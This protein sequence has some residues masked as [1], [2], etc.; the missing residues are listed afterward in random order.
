MKLSLN[1]LNKYL[2]HGLNANDLAYRLTMAGLEVESIENAGDDVIFELEI[3]PNRP[4][5]L[6]VLGL[7]REVSA[8]TDKDMIAPIVHDYEDVA[9]VDIVIED[10]AGCGRYIGTIIEG[11]QVRPLS[12][13]Y[14]S[15]L[16]ALGLKL[17]SNIVDITNFVMFEF[18]Q[19]LHAF[20]LD[21]LEGSKI[22][23][24]RAKKGEKIITLDEVERELDESILVIADARKPVAIAGIMGGRD[25]GVTATTKK[26]LLEAAFFD[27]GVVRRGARRLGL[28]SD[29]CYRFERGVTWKNVEAGSNRATDLIMQMAGGSIS[30]RRDV[31]ASKP[32][33]RRA[34]IIVTSA[35]IQALLGASLEPVRVERILK[36]LG[37]IVATAANGWVVI[38]PHFRNDLRSK[39]DIIEELARVV[40]YDNLPMSLPHVKADNIV[41]DCDKLFFN[42]RVRDVMLAQ[43]FNEVVTY[44]LM[45]RGALDKICYAEPVIR[46]QN[47]M[48]AEHEIMRPT[49]LANLLQ[50]VAYNMNRG[51]KDLRLVEVGKCYVPGRES[52]VLSIVLT[53]RREADWRRPG[54]DNVDFYDLK[55][56][57]EE[58]FTGLRV[59]GCVFNPAE[60]AVLEPGQGATI[61]LNGKTIGYIGKV[62]G[63]VVG[64]FEIKKLNV[65]FAEI[66]LDL[67]SAGVSAR[68]K[69]MPLNDFPAAVRDI[70]LAVKDVSFDSMRGVCQE[71]G[72]GLLKQIEFIELYTGDK[73]EDGYKGYVLSLTYQAPDRTLTDEEVN[74]LHEELVGRLVGR[75]GVKRR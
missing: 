65:F 45:S 67:L 33:R 71:H 7:A 40:G 1:W 31:T 52:L 14:S 48:S 43:G 27:L 28:T 18:G 15:I 11:I 49:A 16:K 47:P 73:L 12:T 39:E 5:C 60:L 58:F 66:D 56:V 10:V 50:V 29:S 41:V 20:D 57:L 23:V 34:E 64:S 30:A 59:R 9:D 17:I 55:G 68:E 53:G 19:P 32:E 42:K 38:P 62:A 70:S 37:C 46:L 4:D 44:S 8:I 6:N 3:T 63:T 36:R 72:R 69:F 26:I 21:K 24:R 35:D 22:I 74:G 54:K 61:A 13:E 2:E 51:H 75:L 25:T